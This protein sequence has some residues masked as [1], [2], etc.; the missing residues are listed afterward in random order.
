MYI[1]IDK[2]GEKG[3]LYEGNIINKSEN[4]KRNG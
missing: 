4:Y 1:N 3:I 2:M